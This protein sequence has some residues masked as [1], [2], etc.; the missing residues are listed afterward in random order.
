MKKQKTDGWE[1]EGRSGGNEDML[2]R[3]ALD[4]SKVD[5]VIQNFAK[6]KRTAQAD[7]SLLNFRISCNIKEMWMSYP[8]TVVLRLMHLVLCRH[9]RLLLLLLRD[10][11]V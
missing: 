9:H 2:F 1:S 3:I 7:L 10:N 6:T 5:N 11:T 8:V 4:V